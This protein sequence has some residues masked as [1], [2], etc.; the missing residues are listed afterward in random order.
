MMEELKG[1]TVIGVDLEY[2]LF[3]PKKG[4]ICLIQISTG[5]KDYIIDPLTNREN[6]AGVIAKIMSDSSV[7]K[8]LHGSDSDLLWLQNDF[9][10]HPVRIFD[11]ARAY[12]LANSDPQLPSLASLLGVFFGLKIDKSFQVAE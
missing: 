6:V 10:A 8:V 7:L 11:T 9:D 3:E 5:E 2:H 1:I 4:C 12:K